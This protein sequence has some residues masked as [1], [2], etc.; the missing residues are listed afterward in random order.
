M[1]CAIQNKI[2]LE[3]KDQKII[4]PTNE[5]IDLKKFNKINN[6]LTNLSESKYGLPKSGGSLYSIINNEAVPNDNLFDLLDILVENHLEDSEQYS[7]STALEELEDEKTKDFLTIVGE[8]VKDN[9][10]NIPYYELNSI[11]KKHTKLVNSI[12]DNLEEKIKKYDAIVKSSKKPNTS[13]QGYNTQL[14]ELLKEIELHDEA[15]Q[16]DSVILFINNI[17]KGIINLTKKFNAEK[18]S[19]KKMDRDDYLH[20][21]NMYNHYLQAYALLGDVSKFLS[22][23]DHSK[24]NIGISQEDINELR[25]KVAQAEGKYNSLKSDFSTLTNNALV[26]ILNDRKYASQV[27]K[28]WRDRLSKE[29][30]ALGIIIPKNEWIQD[31]MDNVYSNEIDEDVR[32]Y[33]EKIVSDPHFDISMATNFL[34]AGINTNS[35]LVQIMQTMIDEVRNNIIEQ[36]RTKDLELKK[37]FDNFIKEKGNKAPSKLYENLLDRD[38]EGNYYLKGEYKVAFREEFEQEK[39]KYRAEFERLRKKYGE[40]SEELDKFEAKNNLTEWLKQNTRKVKVGAASR[41]IPTEKWSLPKSSYTKAEWGVLSHFRKILIQSDKDTFGINSLVSDVVFG[42]RTYKLPSVTKS[43]LERVFEGNTTGMVKDKWKDLTAVRPDDIGYHNTYNGMD[44]NPIYNIRV[45]LRGKLDPSQQSLDL[46]TLMRLEYK[47]S[48]N[49][50]EKHRKEVEL[51][52][53]VQVAKEKEFYASTGTR[54]PLIGVNFKWN[55]RTT[56]DGKDSQTY[57]RLVSLLERNVY[58]IMHKNAG[59]LGP[60]DTNKGIRFVNGWTAAVG[61]TW[62]EVSG[63]ANV[64][65]GKAQLFLE[66]VAGRHIKRSSIIKAEKEYFKHLKE[67]LTDINSPIKTSFVNQ[68]T[69]MF[70]TYGAIAVSAKQAF[71]KNGLLRANL[72]TQSLQFM[73]NSGEHWMQSVLTMAALD[74]IKALDSK[75]RFMDKDGNVVKDEKKAASLYDMLEMVDGKLQM[76]KKVVYS[77]KSQGIKW[78]EGGKELTSK[79]IKKKIFDN[80]G[81]YDENMQAEAMRHSW[82]KLLLLYRKYLIPMGITRFRGFSYI[83]KK[84]ED[85]REEQKFFSEALQEYEEGSYTSAARFLLTTMIPAIKKME[86]NLLSQDWNSLSNA[87]KSNIR[88]T[89]TEITITFALLPLIRM[90]IMAAAGGDDDDDISEFTYFVLLE[91]RRLESE[92][93]SYRDIGEQ[94]RILNSPVPSANMLQN[95]TNLFGRIINPTKWDERYKSGDRK[96]MLKIQ[97]EFNKLVPILNSRNVSYKEKLEF[98]LNQTE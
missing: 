65:N 7:T 87:E 4:S 3:L 38:K 12:K 54:I 78:N 81:N 8:V 98:I 48:I 14:K 49:F 94:Y 42:G 44:G 45:H 5:V 1:A 24:S 79:F 19:I 76:N 20:T 40:E 46:F 59:K 91:I 84:S 51:N 74:S 37:V 32:K 61:M 90:A 39:I 34:N 63:V 31:Q 92:L 17:E 64:L 35:K 70:D 13:L 18:S 55:K 86:L 28:D 2:E 88:K 43:D 36:S 83:D 21:T 68:L 95:I 23:A 72:N 85:L 16:W 30:N 25:S 56:V 62:N 50:K 53:L 77:E 41:T 82:G 15:Q 75:G 27:I 11:A 26:E 66:G 57:R 52:T 22:D 67:N 33:A 93:S 6:K 9:I 10:D 69:D 71:I 47:N 58:D 60:I 80:L 96:D 89:I 73:Q 29:Y 97:R